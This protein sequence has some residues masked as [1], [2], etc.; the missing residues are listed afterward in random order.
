MK[1]LKTLINNIIKPD[2]SRFVLFDSSSYVAR[3][4]TFVSNLGVEA[5][6]NKGRR[7]VTPFIQMCVPIGISINLSVVKVICSFV[8]WA[9]KFVKA[10]SVKQLVLYLKA[11][12]IILQK[13]IAKERLSDLG[14]F[15]VRV[16]R[17]HSGLPRIIPAL[18]RDRIRRGDKLII[19]LWLTLFALLRVLVFNG[20]LDLTSIVKPGKEFNLDKVT[21]FVPIYFYWMKNIWGF[22]RELLAT[23]WEKLRPTAF[24]IAKSGPSLKDAQNVPRGGSTLN[25]VYSSSVLS[26][27]A[28]AKLV[29]ESGLKTTIFTWASEVNVSHLFEKSIV[30]LEAY[31]SLIE[32]LIK[33][34][35]EADKTQ[36]VM[37]SLGKLGFKQEAA[38][39]IRIFAMVDAFT[40]WLLE[41]LH[42]LIFEVLRHIKQDGTHNQLKPLLALLKLRKV[43][44][45]PLYSFD[46][47]SATDRLPVSIQERLLL[48]LLGPKLASL[49][50][51]LLVG[52]TYTYNY[53]RQLK[54]EVKYEVGQP[55]GALSS[56]AML[57]LTHHYLV[58]LAA[59]RAGATRWFT[60]YAVLGDDLVIADTA[61]ANQYLSL[62]EEIGL[63]V[64][65]SK[66]L[67]SKKG[68]ALEFAKRTFFCEEDVTPVTLKNHFLARTSLPCMIDF[69][70]S[71]NLNLHQFLL[72]S[73]Y[74]FKALSLMNLDFVELRKRGHKRL[75][76][77]IFLFVQAKA[78]LAGATIEETLLFKSAHTTY[79]VNS[80]WVI[81]K[82]AVWNS[83]QQSDFSRLWFLDPE[84]AVLPEAKNPWSALYLKMY[85]WQQNYFKVIEGPSGDYENIVSFALSQELGLNKDDSLLKTFANKM[86]SQGIFPTPMRESDIAS[87]PILLQCYSDFQLVEKLM[88]Q[89][90][91]TPVEERSLELFLEIETAFGQVINVNKLYLSPK[92]PLLNTPPVKFLQW[93]RSLQTHF[94]AIAKDDQTSV[95]KTDD[96]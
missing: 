8:F 18:H 85:K 79:P 44:K 5:L 32:K 51:F 17:T 31:W 35:S 57:A 12:T 38:G 16:S 91:D 39:K 11:A 29:R 72:W 60:L 4:K 54:G 67:S 61:V 47:S 53:S 22:N 74:G 87:R 28:A 30:D 43:K 37:G 69:V 59:Q 80:Q 58:Q 66:S 96:R 42:N 73:G 24:T 78:L 70:N 52:R 90:L 9:V 13:F 19:R 68:S 50:R 46:L 2:F 71:Y 7:L 76:D 34:S 49:W 41:P 64:N 81:D 10:G 15:K 25:K 86:E 40:Q 84:L 65:L 92:D 33:K 55:M 75:A 3:L 23:W 77:Q 48:F 27:M 63:G 93:R 20:K 21:S 45:L 36:F 14:P 82:L 6:R 56:W 88:S 94:D 83:E 95:D 89:L 62:C 26:L 1:T